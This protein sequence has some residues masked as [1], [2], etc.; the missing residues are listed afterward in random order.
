MQLLFLEGKN[1]DFISKKVRPGWLE[2]YICKHVSEHWVI[3][4]LRAFG[5]SS[6]MQQDNS[7]LL[8]EK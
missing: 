8:R 2:Q 1:Y 5:P 4:M 7:K 6:E 3:H